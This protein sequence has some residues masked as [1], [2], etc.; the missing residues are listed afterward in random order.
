MCEATSAFGA[1]VLVLSAGWDAHRD[2][3][4]S[5]LAVST[6]AYARIGELYGKLDL[7]TL[8]V[9]EGG[10]SLPAIA[11]ASR[12]FVGAFRASHGVT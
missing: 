9:Q 4:L 5:K 3:P 7:P 8:I 10:Y 12:A 1:D 2:D 11:A 6:D